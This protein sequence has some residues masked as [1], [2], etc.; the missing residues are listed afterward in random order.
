[1]NDIIGGDALIRGKLISFLRRH[2]HVCLYLFFRK[3][4]QRE[5]AR[6]R[7]LARVMRAGSKMECVVLCDF[8][9]LL[10]IQFWLANEKN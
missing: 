3:A 1:M 10:C 7:L 2:R 8:L 4:R 5:L 9:F 6:T